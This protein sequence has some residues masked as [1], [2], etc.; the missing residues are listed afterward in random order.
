MNDIFER[1]FKKKINFS[2]FQHI[3]LKCVYFL[4][5]SNSNGHIFRCFQNIPQNTHKLNVFKLILR[6]KLPFVNCYIK[7]RKLNAGVY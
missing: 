4:D 2:R 7:I 3:T 5:F 6:Y 1:K